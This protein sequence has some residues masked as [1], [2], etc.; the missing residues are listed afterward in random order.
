MHCSTASQLVATTARYFPANVDLVLIEL[1]GA[2]VA[3]QVQWPEVYPGEH[4]P[5]LHRPVV[6][7]D[8]VEVH[9]WGPEDRARW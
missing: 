7:S 2:A 5:H 3:D 9:P 1:D 4:F 8:V 6:A